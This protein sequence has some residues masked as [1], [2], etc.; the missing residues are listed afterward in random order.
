MISFQRPP[1]TSAYS[2][3]PCDGSHDPF[4][5]I[6]QTAL[7]VS[8][9]PLSLSV[10]HHFIFPL[11]KHTPSHPKSAALHCFIFGL[12]I[13]LT[14]TLFSICPSSYLPRSLRSLAILASSPS[15]QCSRVFS[16]QT[17]F[18]KPQK[19]KYISSYR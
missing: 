11:Q 14:N 16:S 13:V 10:A 4:L 9:F 19:N 1:M 6:Q 17:K 18:Y 7:H 2:L 15:H 8:S 12:S 3:V 5:S